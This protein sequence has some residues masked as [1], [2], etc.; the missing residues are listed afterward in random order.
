MADDELIQV[1]EIHFDIRGMSC[2]GCAN[3]IRRTLSN[4]G[5]VVGA[6]VTKPDDMA[7]VGVLKSSGLARRP[8]ILANAIKPLANGKF[9]ATVR[10]AQIDSV[11]V[12]LGVTGLTLENKEAL[13]SQLNAVW[14]V[15]QTSI[16]SA[17]SSATIVATCPEA[18]ILSAIHAPFSVQ[19]LTDAETALDSRETEIVLH[20]DGMGCQSRIEKTLSQLPSVRSAS[21]DLASKKATILG[22]APTSSIL[23]AI[24]SLNKFTARVEKPALGSV[25]IDVPDDIRP[26]LTVKSSFHLEGLTCASCVS[27]VEKAVLALTGVETVSVNLLAKHM[28]V[29]HNPQVATISHIKEAV[30]CAGYEIFHETFQPGIIVLKF[31]API[32]SA[33]KNFIFQHQGVSNVNFDMEANQIQIHFDTR[34][35]TARRLIEHIATVV[36]TFEISSVASTNPTADVLESLKRTKETQY[37]KEKFLYSLIFAIPSFVIFMFFDMIPSL[38]GLLNIILIR[39]ATVAGIIGFVLSTPVQLW[40]ALP[41]YHSAWKAILHH[42]TNMDVLV[43]LGTLSAY[44]FS[45]LSLLLALDDPFYKAEYTFETSIFLITFVL[46]GRYLENYAKG[47]TSVAL[48][49][50][51][52]LQAPYAVLVSNGEEK[53]IDSRLVEI[54]DILRVTPGEKIPADGKILQGEAEIDQSLLTGESMPVLKRQDENVIAGAIVINGTF[55]MRAMHVGT[56][57]MLSKI[58]TLVEQAQTSKPPMQKMVDKISGIFVPAVISASII[59]FIVWYFLIK[60]EI[61]PVPEWKPSGTSDFL[62]AFTFG[63]SVLVIACPCAMGL[64]TPTAVMVGTG[65]AARKGI[66]IKEGKA[67]ETAAKL[68]AVIFD[69]TG[70]LTLGTP[71]VTDFFVV[72]G[73]DELSVLELVAS[74]ES[75][76]NH[77]LA[78]AICT[79]AK[80]K[81]V[82]TTAPTHHQNILGEGQ[83]STILDHQVLIGKL[84]LLQKQKISCPSH[85]SSELAPRLETMGK[86]CIFVSL[87]SRFV[88]LIGVADT[89]RPEAKQV[90]SSLTNRGLDVYLLT[91]DNR[92]TALSVASTLGINNVMADVLP[93]QKVSKVKELQQRGLI[94]AMIGDGINDAPALAQSDVG[95]AVGAGQDVALEA[96]S[97]VLVNSNLQQVVD[98]ISISQR[99]FSRIKLNLLWACF[100]N[101]LAIP[102]A[103]GFIYPIIHPQ[104]LPPSVAALAMALSSVSVVTSSL[105]LQIGETP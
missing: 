93:D 12:R 18:D 64:A 41:F 54:G 59:T 2:S 19:V 45:T 81:S 75:L 61:H 10:P 25:L 104:V 27:K 7:R 83:I 97:V 69:K 23:D 58:V 82:Q 72:D 57:T 24:S 35:T 71:S 44:L 3:N 95:I 100:Y 66:L 77:P 91:G 46:L 47:K 84:S 99:T 103:A 63:V 14:G 60:A 67:F 80:Q 9:S 76:S 79:Y 8:E 40:L 78:R 102:I 20:I 11:V 16:D 4:I 86:T 21:V 37:Y 85:F 26:S 48:T 33:L 31:G 43:S 6:Q 92:G 55:T 36:K 28:S 101:V 73:L 105:L 65:I 94:T 49:K 30:A 22:K 38:S 56:E 74:A 89:I 42:T 68:N 50:L 52:N 62:F 51:I 5:G 13:E 39:G 1:T 34:Q 53:R 88:C 32:T 29:Q 98:A 17:N 70:T 15:W 87:D 90:V 96:A